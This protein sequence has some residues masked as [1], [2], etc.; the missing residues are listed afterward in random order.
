M[1]EAKRWFFQK[2]NKIDKSLASLIKKKR[3]GIQVNEINNKKMR[4]YNW[5]RRIANVH[6]DFLK[7]LDANTMDNM[8]EMD[9]FLGWY[10]FRR[11]SQRKI[12]SILWQ[13]TD[14]EM[15]NVT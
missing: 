9:K 3:E 2:I 4:Y 14:D 13:I 8:K 5:R 15:E 10:K 7:Q 1:D 12:E 6:R 11:L